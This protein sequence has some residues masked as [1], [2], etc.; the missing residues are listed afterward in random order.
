MYNRVLYLS[1]SKLTPRHCYKGLL[2]QLGRESHFYR[3][4]AKRQLHHEIE[5]MRGIH[6]RPVVVY[7]TELNY[8]KKSC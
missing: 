5:L 1:D 8:P 2:E 3:G 6:R 4:D 7:F